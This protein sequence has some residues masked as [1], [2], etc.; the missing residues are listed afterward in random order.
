VEVAQPGSTGAGWKKEL[1]SG[2]H[3]SARGERDSVENGRSELK[4]KTS[5]AKYTKGTRGPSG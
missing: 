5:F 4:K 2:A 3:A 1:T